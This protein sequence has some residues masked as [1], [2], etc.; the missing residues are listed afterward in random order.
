[1]IERRVIHRTAARPEART[2]DLVR[3]GLARNGVGQMRDATWM[4]WR[5]TA[6]E[7]RHGEIKTAPEEMHR[8]RLAEEA[9]AELF[10]H[11][12][13]VD[14]D[15]QEA[16]YRHRIVGGMRGVLREA[17]RLRQLVRH[18]V[19]SKLNAQLSQRCQD[20]GVEARDGLS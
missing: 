1:G 11:A 7:S 9:G 20:I 10:E 3:I 14:E 8:A 2:A 13:A 17:R 16:L 6:G 5:D 19:D 12:V 18:V 4:A 15:L